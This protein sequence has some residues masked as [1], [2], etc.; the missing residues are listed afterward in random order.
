M[1]KKLLILFSLILSYKL[2]SNIY[3]YVRCKSLQIRYHKWISGNDMNYVTYKSEVIKLFKRAN[4]KDALASVSEK[5]VPGS[6]TVGQRSVQNNF[7]HCSPN[8]IYSADRMFYEAIG[9]YR[10]RF[11][12]CFSPLYWIESIIFLP[13]NILTY[14]NLDSEKTAFKL[15]NVLLSFIWWVIIASITIF[16]IDFENLIAKYIELLP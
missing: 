12:E 11:K 4:V 2:L 7:P 9:L 14:I 3:C 8:H 15:A 5:P 16:D 6:L 13:K 10:S 1:L